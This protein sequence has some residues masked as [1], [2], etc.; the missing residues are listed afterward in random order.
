MNETIGAVH[1]IGRHSKGALMGF[2]AQAR[3]ARVRYRT[4]LIREPDRQS[5]FYDVVGR[6]TA[7]A[8]GVAPGLR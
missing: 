2:V 4:R 8:N 1:C 5:G 6:A 3:M 7:R